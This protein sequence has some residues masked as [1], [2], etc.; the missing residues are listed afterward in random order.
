[1][2][3][4]YTAKGLQMIGRHIACPALMGCALPEQNRAVRG[5]QTPN[6]ASKFLCDGLGK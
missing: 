2:F 6:Q 3:A 4:A 1:M 5:A